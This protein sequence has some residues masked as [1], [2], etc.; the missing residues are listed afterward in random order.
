M[1]KMKIV[2][3]RYVPAENG[4]DV[5][6]VLV[7]GRVT[8]DRCVIVE[9]ESAREIAERECG[10]LGIQIAGEGIELFLPDSDE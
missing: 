4:R 6:Y 7:D 5:I 10:E 8:V 9:D 3:C 1:T 2:G